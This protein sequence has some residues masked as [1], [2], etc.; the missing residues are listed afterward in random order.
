VA[1]DFD[2]SIGNLDEA[3]SR[4]WAEN[5]FSAS[6]DQYRIGTPKHVDLALDFGHGEYGIAGPEP[7]QENFPPNSV[8]RTEP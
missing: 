7:H 6:I 5:G 3:A 4:Q 1:A 8:F 2:P